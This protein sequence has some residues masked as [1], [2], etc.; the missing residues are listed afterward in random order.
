MVCAMAI[1][2]TISSISAALV[3]YSYIIPTYKQEIAPDPPK[4]VRKAINE[5]WRRQAVCEQRENDAAI[6]LLRLDDRV[7]NLQEA[8][9]RHRIPI[10][11]RPFRPGQVGEEAPTK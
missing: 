1:G 4:D 9:Q 10:V 5:L 3:T 11:P 7:D 6:E 2:S 8:L